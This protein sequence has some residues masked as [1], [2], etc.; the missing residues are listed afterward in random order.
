MFL[1]RRLKQQIPPNLGTYLPSKPHETLIRKIDHKDKDKYWLIFF[2][3][4]IG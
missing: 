2:A 3:F 1:P 4:D